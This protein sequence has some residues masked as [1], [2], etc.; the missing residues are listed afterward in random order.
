MLGLALL[1]LVPTA[2]A[3][4]RWRLGL[5][6]FASRPRDAIF[7]SAMASGCSG[8]HWLWSH[9]TLVVAVT[10][11]ELRVWVAFPLTLTFWG[12]L[13]DLEHRVP[14]TSVRASV[15][16]GFMRPIARAEFVGEDGRPRRLDL[17][18]SRPE[19]FVRAI[20]RGGELPSHS[21]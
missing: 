21:P 15:L 11:G 9:N 20:Q 3:I 1:V 18:F 5:P 13:T 4:L 14:R 16:S 12:Q 10:P 2:S 19:N 8:E 7:F 6:I 17:Q